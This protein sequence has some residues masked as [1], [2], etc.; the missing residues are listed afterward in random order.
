MK[1]NYFHPTLYGALLF[2]LCSM[3][4]SLSANNTSDHT[5][6]S[7]ENRAASFA[8]LVFLS[9]DE[10]LDNHFSFSISTKIAGPELENGEF[11]SKSNSFTPSNANTIN[12]FSS[13]NNSSPA[14]PCDL[15][16]EA[17]PDKSICENG[18]VVLTAQTSGNSNYC[19]GTED[20]NIAYGFYSCL[21]VQSQS[22]VFYW[23]LLKPSLAYNP[24][25][26]ASHF[27]PITNNFLGHKCAI[28]RDTN[29]GKLGALGIYASTVKENPFDNP[30][31]DRVKV[32]FDITIS[33]QN[34][35][36][37]SLKDISFSYAATSYIS[38][39]DNLGHTVTGQVAPPTKYAIRVTRDG[40]EI[41][42]TTKSVAFNKWKDELYEFISDS[43]FTVQNGDTA[44]FT[45]ELFG[46]GAGTHFSPM[47]KIDRFSATT[48]CA[49][50][51]NEFLWSTG[52][53][54][55]SI[56]V[57]EPGE[58]SVTVSNGD[59]VT[60]D[61]VTVTGDGSIPVEVEDKEICEG[62]EVILTAEVE[63]NTVCTDCV[64]EKTGNL[65][66]DFD[67]CLAY[68][69]SKS[70]AEFKPEFSGELCGDIDASIV[71]NKLGHSCTTDKN[72]NFGQ[73]MC[74]RGADNKTNPFADPKFARNVLRFEV[75]LDPNE[76]QTASINGFAFDQAAP[77]VAVQTDRYGRGPLNVE[78]NPPQQYAIRVSKNG[79]IIYSDVRNTT[80]SWAAQNFDFSNNPDF[81]INGEATKF[82]FE[83]LPFNPLERVDNDNI[84][85][86]V[87][88]FELATSCCS[89]V[90]TNSSLEYLWSTGETTESITVSPD[91]T[92]EYTVTV[93]NCKGCSGE[94]TAIVTVQDPQVSVEDVE[95]CEGETAVL[96]AVT[97]STEV[98]FLWSNGEITKSIE[99]TEAGEYTVTIST[100]NGCESEA[101]A[102]VSIIDP[103][104]GTIAPD[105]EEVC[106]END[107]T[108][109]SA[110]PDGSANVPDGY[111]LAYVLTSGDNLVVQDLGTEPS[112]EVSEPGKYTIHTFVYPNSFDPLSVVT[113]GVT[114]GGEVAAL[115]FENGGDALCASL[116]VDGA[117]VMV[118]DLVVVG[119]F[120][121]V[122][123]D[124]NGLQDD[125]ATGINGVSATLFQNDGTE[126]ASTVTTN[127]P[128]TNEPGYYSFEVCPN[129]GEYYIVFEDLPE[130]FE[131][132]GQNTG[133]DA[134]DS[135]IDENGRTDTFEVL[136]QDNL[137][138]DSGIFQPLS[139][140][141]DT[142]FL[143]EDQDGIQDPGEEGVDGVIVN[144][145]DCEGNQL[146][147]TTTD[148][149]GNYSFTALDPNIDYIV[150]FELP[151][152]FAFSPVDAGGDDTN[153]SDAGMDGRTPCTDLDPGENDPTLDAGIFQPL[154]SLGDTVFLDEDQDGIQD[155]GEEG[156]DGVIVNLLDCEGNQL[157]TTT[158]DENGNYS[159]TALDPNVDYIVEFELPDG[160]AFSPVDAGGDDANDSDAG[161]D[162]RTPCT[163]LDPGENDPTLDAGIFM[164]CDIDPMVSNVDPICLG[165]EVTL[166]ATGG[167]T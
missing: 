119:D 93:K 123:E 61:T 75:T 30:A 20:T 65:S 131:V 112:F 88:S 64:D 89:D 56:Q 23:G 149:N 41:Y 52:E 57:S 118:N 48:G 54:S 31:T 145:L 148:A 38:N 47:W 78:N 101:T 79:E 134:L 12:G 127:N 108:V 15:S 162:G 155:P 26:S 157:D 40:Q 58:Y 130:G 7:K 153:D 109:I 147:T 4:A 8:P 129:S 27:K 137:T 39:T 66:Y 132:T 5:Y 33:P 67:E 50:S 18:S 163:D 74:F 150:E 62:E 16:V 167:D 92:S 83:L 32:G 45:I 44:K 140:L 49:Q 164:S 151:E 63:D 97:E 84:I 94:A 76:N 21:S 133:D 53:T 29:G 37:V 14:P 139:S 103:E 3:P 46:Y 9:L 136:D 152:G 72:G 35:V 141:G 146:D 82:K 144:L 111:T 142:V 73:A 11:Y 121:W 104:A 115:L 102:N 60:T 125:G 138:I 55:K 159:F 160:F 51:P 22:G 124:Q 113:P 85:W 96:T 25:V 6:A 70:F 1:K 107:P 36:P 34:G 158:T 161:M 126:I 154:A 114:T 91:E 17:G 43:N 24:E 42:R 116:D 120:A 156:V 105:A 71:F 87:D 128:D 165:T 68:E 110:I 86:D 90:Q 117:M 100:A 98:S 95:V 81:D 13:L 59:C 10:N 166:T 69:N 99:V 77:N 28:G 122:D 143:D 135:D 106:L 19:Q 80:A 2:L